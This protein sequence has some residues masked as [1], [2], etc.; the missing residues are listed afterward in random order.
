MTMIW[1]VL[2][3]DNDSPIADG[4]VPLMLGRLDITDGASVTLQPG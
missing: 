3:D 1:L 4:S 2:P